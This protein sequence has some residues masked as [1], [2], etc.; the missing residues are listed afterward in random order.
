MATLGMAREE[1][2]ASAV[3]LL[4]DLLAVHLV[5]AGALEYE[6]TRTYIDEIM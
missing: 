2:E 1:A 6:K 5:E 3:G 4:E